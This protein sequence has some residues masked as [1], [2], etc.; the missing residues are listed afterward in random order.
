[1]STTAKSKKQSGGYFREK[2]A[3]IKAKATAYGENLQRSYTHGYSQGTR[4]AEQIPACTFSVTAATVGY[5]CGLRDMRK[6][7]KYGKK[8]KKGAKQKK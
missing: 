6:A 2:A 1:M 4:D 8:V 5:G 7:N 3:Q